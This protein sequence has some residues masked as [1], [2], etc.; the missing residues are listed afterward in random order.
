MAH[1]SKSKSYRAYSVKVTWQKNG[2]PKTTKGAKLHKS[3]LT[4]GQAAELNSQTINTGIEY[5]LEG[6][7]K[8]L[9]VKPSNKK[10]DK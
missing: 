3:I 1:K 2:A 4:D 8:P 5:L 9:V 7:P 10:E 6:N